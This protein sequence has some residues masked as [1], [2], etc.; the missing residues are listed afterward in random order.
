MDFLSLNQTAN[1][2]I[3]LEVCFSCRE[4]YQNSKICDHE[5]PGKIPI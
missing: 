5:A 2:D 3:P 4:D 1:Q